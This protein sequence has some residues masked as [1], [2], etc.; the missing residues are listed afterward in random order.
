MHFNLPLFDTRP[1]F[2]Y[3]SIK[4]R[5]QWKWL[6]NLCEVRFKGI[7]S[8]SF[9]SFILSSLS[10]PLS[11]LLLLLFV[12]GFQILYLEGKFTR[13]HWGV[14][15]FISSISSVTR[16]DTW[17]VPFKTF[18]MFLLSY[19]LYITFIIFFLKSSTGASGVHHGAV[20]SCTHLPLNHIKIKSIEQSSLR[21]FWSIVEQKS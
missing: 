4:Y 2:V 13:T 21:T 7:V 9:F 14:K 10:H 12:I 5:T 3:T 11:I 15:D 6:F 1:A 20:K 19:F 17:T 8:S 18:R 16:L